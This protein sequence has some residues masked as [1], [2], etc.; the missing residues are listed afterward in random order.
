MQDVL[1]ESL[2]QQP[3]PV[4]RQK[5]ITDSEEARLRLAQRL[6]I[7]ESPTSDEETGAN[8]QHW[9]MEILQGSELAETRRFPDSLGKP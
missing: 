3:Q 2:E 6:P 1:Q 5:T 4:T 9:S 7:Q 8:E